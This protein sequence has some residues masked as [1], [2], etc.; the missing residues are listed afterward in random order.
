MLRLL[1]IPLVLLGLLAVAL[2]WS[3]EGSQGRAD[4]AF[5]NRGDHVT[6]DLN[7]MSYLQDIRVANALWEGLYTLDPATLGPVLG[8]A[9]H[10]G[11]SPDRRTYTFHI[12]PDAKWS[13]GDPVTAGDYLFEW[14]RMVESPKE[15][16]YL[17]H[18]LKGAEAYEKAYAD[19]AA[20]PLSHKPA[21]PDFG[22]V[23]MAV[24]AD[25]TLRVTLT[26]PVPFF[27][28]LLAFAPFF[29]M[30]EPSMAPF[31][32]TDADTGTVTY[33]PTFTRPPNL[34]TNGPFR[35]ASWAFKRRVRMDA[36]PYYW[37]RQ[38]VRCRTVDEVRADDPLAAYRL[39]E[40]GE[41]DWIADVDPDLAAPL[42]QRRRPDLHVFPAFGTYFYELNCQPKLADGSPN[43]LADVRVRQ[44]LAMSVQKPP[45][46]DNVGRLDQP[47]TND[48][49]PPGAFPG[50]AS[51]AGL[52][53]DPARA[54][55]L[56]A[57]AGYPGGHG[58]PRISILYDTAQ[59]LHGDI[60]T[61]VRRQWSTQLGINVDPN[62]EEH[63][64]YA[65]DLHHQQYTV[66]RAS[67]YGDYFDP[68]T[69]TD[70]YLSGSDNN[71]A[72]WA[73]PQYD[74]TCGKAAAEPDPAKR[75]A[76]FH[77]A[78]AR[79]LDQ[80][81]IVPLYTY[82]N[83]YLYPST[84]HGITPNAQGVVMFKAVWTDHGAAASAA[85]H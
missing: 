19:Y 68:S 71:A 20:A 48:F 43:P 32:R 2:L 29:P 83:T 80:A 39:Y 24:N 76:D 62:G 57:D 65:A 53:Y 25:G 41:V 15:Y 5:V 74:A 18:Y 81:P 36:N 31:K 67:W 72:R 38:N 79:L 82:V 50:Y 70:K 85:M 58:F 60:A 84:V 28:A 13:N 63:Q 8:T 55:Q 52:P 27:P 66:A 4:F 77:D 73:D 45:I 75:L 3:G 6:L 9:D 61:I 22:T 37:D 59:T 78:E 11:L 33:D 10:V 54:R 56:L 30:H 26:N 34:V 7:N 16:T 23:G 14:R 21:T 17:Y 69:F 42:L 44:A 49:I 12:R 46:V 64:Q 1:A 51:P 47:V 40:Q 35:L